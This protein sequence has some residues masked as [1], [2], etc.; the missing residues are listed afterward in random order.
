MSKK[1]SYLPTLL[2]LL[3]RLLIL[4][5][6]IFIIFE[7]GLSQSQSL[8]TVNIKVAVDEEYRSRKMWRF[9]I[10]RLISESSKDFEKYFGIR[11]RINKF[12]HWF[13]DNSRESTLELLNDLRKKVFKR[14]CDIVLGF[15]SQPSLKYD[16]SGAATY[17]HDYI[18]LRKLRSEV[19]MKS[20]LSHELSHLFGA[21][22]LNEKGS[23]MHGKNLGHESDKFTT[24]IILLNKNRNFNP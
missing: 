18:V 5:S 22:D 15:T 23:I 21:A 8:R 12:D 2:F 3:K 20:M 4:S 13:S 14:D 6:L 19:A 10:K 16:F 7:I 1:S 24:R 11:F 17:L 9:E